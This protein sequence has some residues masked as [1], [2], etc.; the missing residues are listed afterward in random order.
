MSSQKLYL[1]LHP[2]VASLALYVR[3]DLPFLEHMKMRRHVRKCPTC[4]SEVVAF[5]NGTDRL[6]QSAMDEALPGVDVNWHRLEREM[7]GNIAVGVAAAR[8]IDNV[9]KRR[10]IFRAGW[11][12]AGLALLFV[13]GW[14]THIPAAE[15]ERLFAAFKGAFIPPAVH[16]GTELKADAEGIAVESQGATLTLMHPQSAVVS[17]SGS[18]A[19]TARYLDE[20]S[21]QVT[22]TNVYAQ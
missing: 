14:F 21:G 2:S 18:S 11:L 8:C 1:D 13:L 20:D 12:I 15:N 6:R 17:L 4:R 10:V 22:I 7:L 3:R 9:G 19:L 16:H 5:R